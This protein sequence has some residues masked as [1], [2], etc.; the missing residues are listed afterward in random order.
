MLGNLMMEWNGKEVE[1]D[2]SGNGKILQLFLILI[3][4]GEKGINRGRLQDYLYDMR[5]DNTGNALRVSLSRLRRQLEENE[6]LMTGAIHYKNG[7]YILHVPGISIEADVIS[8]ENTYNRAQ[9]EENVDARLELL[10]KAADCYGGEFLPAMSGESWV[11]SMRGRYQ[12]MYVD[13]VKEACRLWKKRGEWEK[14]AALCRDALKVCPMEEWSELLIESLLSLKQY[15][16]AK[17][18]YNDGA[19]L[20]FG[21]DSQEPSRRRLERFRKIGS[22]IKM[23]ERERQ[24][25]KDELREPGRKKGAY[26]CNYPGFLDCFHMCA[27]ISER[28]DIGAYLVICSIVSRNGREVQKEEELREYSEMLIGVMGERLRRGDVYTVYR[29]DCLLILL[30]HVEKKNV[31]RVKER[32]RSGFREKSGGRA[33]LRLEILKLSE[34]PK[35]S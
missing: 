2:L 35:G 13:C 12:E 32:I 28:R 25:V 29:P 6:V 14:I 22:Q 11:E 33:T 27:R 16:E 31:E 5:T 17:K 26:F 10:E 19:K 34:W 8:F 30:S 3:W 24:D 7:N 20:F 9:A 15:R 4:A 23:M 1:K 21:H 18:A